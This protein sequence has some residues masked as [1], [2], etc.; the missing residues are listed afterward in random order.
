[1]I[2]V[3]IG[4]GAAWGA[5]GTGRGVWVEVGQSYWSSVVRMDLQGANFNARDERGN[6]IPPPAWSVR[7]KGGRVVGSGKF[8]FG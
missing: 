5:S 8:E 7:T 6:L 3:L 4:A 2:L 1:V